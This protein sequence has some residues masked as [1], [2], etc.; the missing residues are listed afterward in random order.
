MTADVVA[1]DRDQ[2]TDG[3]I[4]TDLGIEREG[5]IK[6]VGPGVVDSA[7]GWEWFGC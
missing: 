6:D 5:R 7:I 4:L 3:A 1:V 2:K